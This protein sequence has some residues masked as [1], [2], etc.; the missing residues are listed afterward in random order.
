M[1]TKWL[2]KRIRPRYNSIVYIRKAIKFHMKGV[3]VSGFYNSIC[4]NV[5]DWNS[6]VGIWITKTYPDKVIAFK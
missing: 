4:K 5:D 2:N 1:I 3:D 6:E